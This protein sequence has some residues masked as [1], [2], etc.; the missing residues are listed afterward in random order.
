MNRWPVILFLAILASG[1]CGRSSAPPK[2]QAKPTP[3]P[4][5]AIT[6]KVPTK[7][8]APAESQEVAATAPETEPPPAEKKL[9]APAG[10]VILLAP[11]GP[12]LFDLLVTIDGEALPDV[13]RRSVAELVER[14]TKS[15]GTAL[16]WEAA[17]SDPRFSLGQASPNRQDRKILIATLDLNRDQIVQPEEAAEYY[18]RTDSIGPALAFAVSVQSWSEREASR[19][20]RLA[21]LNQDDAI[22]AEELGQLSST[23]ASHDADGN[24]LIDVMELADRAPAN[25]MNAMQQAGRSARANPKLAMLCDAAFRGEAIAYTLEE[26]Y[27]AGQRDANSLSTVDRLVAAVDKNFNLRIDGRESLA[28]T[29]AAPQGRIY[30]TYGAVVAPDKSVSLE[31]VDADLAA[32]SKLSAGANS[33][34]SELAGNRLLVERNVLAAAPP[35]TGN[36]LL[37]QF[38]MLDRDAN[39]Y[40]EKSELPEGNMELDRLFRAADVDSDGKLYRPEIDDFVHWQQ[41]L[42]AASVRLDVS[43]AA[44]PLFDILDTSHDGRLS[45]RELRAAANALSRHDRNGDDR[46]TIDDLP[47]EIRLVFDRFA[48]VEGPGAP[49]LRQAANSNE[50]VATPGESQSPAAPEWFVRMDLNGDGDLSAAEFLGTRDQFDAL[51]T[52]R[53]GFITAAEAQSAK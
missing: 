22:D 15:T 49:T 39:L 34:V 40:L 46:L 45:Q 44:D 16:T 2:P 38:A 26:L 52:D 9:V 53:D 1:G 10:R 36:P 17:L 20:W 42:R 24:E 6:E 32:A 8:V 35:G 43:S 13:R 48:P 37:T 41:G 28:L 23:L 30:V 47:V 33:L 31:W 7:P 3:P 51:D 18:A 21:D 12:L 5:V 27:P 4:A 14:L 11:V 19:L 25:N 50:A 29:Q